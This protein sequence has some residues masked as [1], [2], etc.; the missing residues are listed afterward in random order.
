L[1]EEPVD[2]AEPVSLLLDPAPPDSDEPAPMDPLAPEPLLLLE[3]AAPESEEPAPMEPLPAEPVSL[4][5]PVEFE[6]EEP[7]PKEP[8][9]AE[10][11]SLLDPVPPSSVEP[12]LMEPL[13][14]AEPEPELVDVLLCFFVVVVELVPLDGL[15][16]SDEL[17]LLMEP[18]A[19]EPPVS[20]ALTPNAAAASPATTRYLSLFCIPVHLLDFPPLHAAAATT[21]VHDPRGRPALATASRP[22]RLLQWRSTKAAHG[23]AWH[24]T[25][26]GVLR[27][28]R[29]SRPGAA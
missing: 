25:E 9:P 6:S 23:A 21:G 7:A 16:A 24:N 17:S 3:P 11:V 1:P 18:P 27:L 20:P 29:G 19:P 15:D 8:L 26:T 5:D 13:V 28:E 10:P 12:E 14:P 4:L 22:S 2:P